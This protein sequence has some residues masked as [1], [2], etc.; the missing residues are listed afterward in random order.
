MSVLARFHAVASRYQ[1]T[2][3]GRQWFVGQRL[4]PSPAV[5]ERLDRLDRWPEGRL[6]ESAQRMSRDVSDRFGQV[7]TEIIRRFRHAR[8]NVRTQLLAMSQRPVPLHP[9]LRDVW[10]DHLLFTGDEVTGL[11]DT[12]ATRT[13]NV[14]SDLSRLLGSLL[15]PWSE[16]WETALDWY[17]Q[18]RRLSGDERQLVQV[19]HASGVLL[20]G[21]T[22]IERQMAGSIP[23]DQLPAVIARMES[24]RDQFGD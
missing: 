9:C 7:A 21:M 18:S 20:S 24:I 2:P 5:K 1:P 6:E 13:E 22:W 10:H 12:A 23:D 16:R 11:V 17:S 4:A 8:D 15:G 19:L 14:A 3:G